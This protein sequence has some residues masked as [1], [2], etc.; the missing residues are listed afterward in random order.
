LLMHVSP[1]AGKPRPVGEAIVNSLFRDGASGRIPLVAVLATPANGATLDV[2]WHVLKGAGPGAGRAGLDGA[3]IDGRQLLANPSSEKQAA[4]FVLA[5]D[6]VHRALLAVQPSEI[7]THGLAVDLLHS[8]ILG[9]LQDADHATC[10]A[11]RVLVQNLASAGYAVVPAA[12]RVARS[13]VRGY[14]PQ[15]IFVDAD[16]R[17]PTLVAHRNQGQVVV[18]LRKGNVI[19]ARGEFEI[20]LAPLTQLLKQDDRDGGRVRISAVLAAAA[21]AWSLDL[22]SATLRHGLAAGSFA[23]DALVN[24]LGKA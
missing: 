5:N 12:D 7:A 19:L 18:F 22:P 16:E 8:V 3:W 6:T 10:S 21:V 4:D 15:A 11:A 14:L 9:P 13:V 24:G 1:A 2:L 23:N 17:Y 20:V